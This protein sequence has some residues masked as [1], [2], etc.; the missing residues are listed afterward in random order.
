M[1]THL[2]STIV[3]MTIL[4]VA[5]G[6]RASSPISPSGVAPT[7]SAAGNAVVAGNVRLGATAGVGSASDPMKVQVVGTDIVATVSLAGQF[8]LNGVPSG[9]IQLHFFGA[10]VDATVTIG[11]IA[12]GE[13]VTISVTV[14]GTTA[15]VESEA[16]KASDQAEEQIEGRIESL[17]PTQAAG[18]FVVAGRTVTTTATTVFKM[19]SVTKTFADLEIGQRAHVKGTTTAGVFTASLVDI[20]NVQTDLP[21]NVNGVVSGLTGSELA[22]QFMVDERTIAGDHLT[23][24]YGN[25]GMGSFTSLANGVRV[26]VK[27]QQRDSLIYAVRIHVNAEDD[28]LD[29]FE[30]KG[31]LVSLTG[32]CPAYTFV[33]AGRT[34]T[35]DA[36]TQFKGAACADVF[37][38]LT[39]EV[40]GTIQADGTVRARKVTIDKDDLEFESK[41]VIAGLT[42]ACPS[43]VFTIGGWTV[44]TNAS[45]QFK[46]GACSAI[47]NGDQAEVK[48]TK[49]ADGTVLATRVDTEKK[50]NEDDGKNTFQGSGTISG[51]SG[52]CPALSFTLT[53]K[54]IAVASRTVGIDTNA[55]TTFEGASCASLKNGYTIEVKGTTQASGRVL[56]TTIEK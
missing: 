53:V 5:C 17:P 42:G 46:G 37:N 6:G 19:G 23:V 55:A 39:I 35:T 25:G 2:L 13:T 41:G 21:V 1:R 9:Q 54:G 47:A 29:E 3:L 7:V 38:G 36:S 30:A 45:T 12:T 26:E 11:Q 27:G 52:T 20:Q 8:V 4:T 33:L 49:Q 44:R 48:G 15:V 10:G 22:F 40:E 32:S 34:V 18:A 43:L 16:R 31:T 51:L 24:F 14:V 28:D 50:K 56:A